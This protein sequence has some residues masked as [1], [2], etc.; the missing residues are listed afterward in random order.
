MAIDVRVKCSVCL[1]FGR[2]QAACDGRSWTNTSCGGRYHT[3]SQCIVS[4]TLQQLVNL[5]RIM[6]VPGIRCCFAACVYCK[7]YR[8]LRKVR[9]RGRNVRQPPPNVRIE[10]SGAVA[11]ETGSSSFKYGLFG[12]VCVPFREPA[13]EAHS[14]P[15]TT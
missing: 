8:R 11:M 15:I 5:G 14:E 6:C 12:T 13:A 3:L 1:V 9:F 4:N 10:S 7:L 2:N